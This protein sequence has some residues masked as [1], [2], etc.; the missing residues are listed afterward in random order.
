MAVHV[1]V[2]FNA[3]LRIPYEEG[4]WRRLAGLIGERWQP[5]ARDFGNLPM[6][7]V[8]DD[9]RRPHGRPRPAA[10][11]VDP[12]ERYFDIELPDR[13]RAGKLVRRLRELGGDIID[14]V[15]L[16]GRVSLAQRGAG[17][18]RGFDGVP[19]GQRYFLPGPQGI[20]A[21]GA[22]N[23]FQARGSGVTIADVETGWYLRHRALPRGIRVMCGLNA[24]NKDHG[25][26]VM[27]IL[28]ALHAAQEV[29]GGAP[30]AR[31]IAASYV[32]T[33]NDN[34]NVAWAINQARK[35]LDPGDILLLE[36]TTQHG[37]IVEA[38]VESEAHIR[39]AIERCTKAGILVIEPAGNS[40]ANLDPLGLG[41]RHSGALVVGASAHRNGSRHRASGQRSLSNYG[42]RVNCFAWGHGIRTLTD[43]PDGYQD[44]H[45]TSGAAAI[46]AVAAALL[47]SVAR[48]HLKQIGRTPS[49]LTPEES[50]TYLSNPE[51]GT[52]SADRARRPIGVMPNLSYVIE[53]FLGDFPVPRRRRPVKHKIQKH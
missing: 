29:K 17:T 47:Q 36:V 38:P 8:F 15:Y 2:R 50:L 16:R 37:D 46:I 1:I 14:E 41:D 22:W 3:A 21:V 32:R 44:F 11:D 33:K 53:R 40:G 6:R 27:G 49:Y 19:D 52:L 26:A 13:A 12:T 24:S 23:L 42:S 10:P 31:A 30:D 51:C 9:D 35:K 18:R 20:D 48:R 39:A 34:E 4:I 5:I 25:A 45:G 7:R 28:V 43:E